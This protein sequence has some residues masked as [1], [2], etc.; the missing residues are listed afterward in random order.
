MNVVPMK[1]IASSSTIGY[2][3]VLFAYH[4]LRLILV[5]DNGPSLISHEFHKFLKVNDIKHITM[6]PC[7]PVINGQ[8]ERM[9]SKF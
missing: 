8:A 1:N 5:S 7:Y 2:L 3:W 4:S 9:V 6:A